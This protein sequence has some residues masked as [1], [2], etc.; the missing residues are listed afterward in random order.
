MSRVGRKK[1]IRIDYTPTDKQAMFHTSWANYILYGGQAGGGKSRAFREDAKNYCLKIPGLTVGIFRRTTPELNTHIIPSMKEFPAP[2]LCTYNKKNNW[3]QFVNGSMLMF[4]YAQHEDDIFKYRSTEF[5]IIYIDEATTFTPFQLQFIKGRL[6]RTIDVSDIDGRDFSH[7]IPGM[8]MSSNPG[9]VSHEYLKSQFVTGMEAFKIVPVDESWDEDEDKYWEYKQYI[10]AS[11]DDNPHIDK[12]YKKRLE[13]YPEPWRSAYLHGSWDIH[14]GQAFNFLPSRHILDP[15]PEVPKYGPI[16]MSYDYGFGAP[17]SIG[18]W[19]TDADGRLYRFA[20]W[21]GWD[22][23]PN[24]GMRLPDSEVALEILRRE[25]E[26]GLEN[27]DIYR[28]TGRD[29]FNKEPDK[30]GGG[31]GPSTAD[32]F[33]KVNE[34]LVLNPGD[35]DR[36]LK[37]RQFRQRMKVP[38]DPKE[39]PMIVVSPSCKHFIRTIPSIQTHPRN[40]EDIDERGEDHVYD[41]VCL[42]CMMHQMDTANNYQGKPLTPAQIDHMKLRGHWNPVGDVIEQTIFG[43]F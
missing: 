4:C 14:E 2:H 36:K 22:G 31:Q 1:D 32:E 17:F 11:V 39:M 25:K 34:R 16:Y 41:E 12:G 23:T 18:W 10:P 7:K 5:D 24:K 29:S 6:R 26:M 20:E 42:V 27:R 38:D 19:F 35:S 30:R 3:W 33:I 37:I 40:P 13:Q 43:G 15:F 8:Y 21:Y 9:G 28:I